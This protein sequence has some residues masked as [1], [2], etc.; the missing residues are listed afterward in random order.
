MV[1]WRRFVLRRMRS[2]DYDESEEVRSEKARMWMAIIALIVFFV[3]VYWSFIEV[4]YL[5]RAESVPGTVTRVNP[6]TASL[7]RRSERVR[8]VEF[9]YTDLTGNERQGVQRLIETAPYHDGQ[10]ITVQYIPNGR[11]SLPSR[12]KGEGNLWAIWVTLGAIVMSVIAI[13]RIAHEANQPFG[14][15]RASRRRR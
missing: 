6:D 7:R 10:A 4:Q 1:T 8:H 3:S 2:R 12:I 14:Q 11:S 5:I 13:V 9:V 15:P